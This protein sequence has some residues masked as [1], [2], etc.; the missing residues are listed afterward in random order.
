MDSFKRIY[1]ETICPDCENRFTGDEV[2][3]RCNGKSVTNSAETIE[4]YDVSLK[5][6]HGKKH[7]IPAVIRNV[8]Q[9]KQSYRKVNFSRV[10]VFKRDNY[11]CQYCGVKAGE[12]GVILEMEHVVPR[13][14]WNGS[15][16]P[17]CWT[18]IV[19]A[20]RKCNRKKDDYFQT[21]SKDHALESKFH[22]Y[23]P[24]FKTID[25]ERVEYRRPKAPSRG[26]FHLSVDFQNMRK[27]PTEWMPYIEHLLK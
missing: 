20:C 13:S 21:N 26:D 8:R 1:K 5:D 3:T 22:V 2:C 18:N 27:I 10:N 14:R 23:M 15:G 16:S 6:G 7:F 11:T 25:G 9:V 19:A 24:L 4:V 12:E 17:T